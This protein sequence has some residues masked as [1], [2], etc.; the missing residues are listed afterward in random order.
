MIEEN[1]FFNSMTWEVTPEEGKLMIW[2][3]WLLHYVKPNLSDDTRISIAFNTT[4][5]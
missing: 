2:P 1:N 4:V 3:S 5:S